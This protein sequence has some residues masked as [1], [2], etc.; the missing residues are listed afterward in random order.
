MKGGHG[1][2][3]KFLVGLAIG[4]LWFGL[5]GGNTFATTISPGGTGFFG[6]LTDLGYFAAGEYNITGSGVIDLAGD[7]SFLMRPDGLP[8]SAVT[9]PDYL[10]F[11]PNG[12]YIADAYYGPAGTNAKIGALIGTFSPTPISWDDWFLIGYSTQVTLSSAR[13]IYA[14]VN[15]VYYD[16]NTGF[17][18]ATVSPAPVP[19]PST[20]LLLA[21]GLVG[22]AGFRKRFKK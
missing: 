7:G 5:V 19:E 20:M 14:S 21:S 17:F 15:D 2:I 16:N 6:I 11:N 10:Y 22:L 8:V 1:M 12:T 4:F 18:E 3:K 13:H 9:H